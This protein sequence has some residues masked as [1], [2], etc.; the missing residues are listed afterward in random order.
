MEGQNSSILKDNSLISQQNQQ[1]PQVEQTLLPFF[2]SSSSTENKN[3][4]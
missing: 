1:V 3:S 4:F 2:S